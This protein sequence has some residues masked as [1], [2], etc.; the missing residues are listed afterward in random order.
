MILL[1]IAITSVT[2]TALIGAILY[3]IYRYKDSVNTHR[4]D[5]VDYNALN[6]SYGGVNGSGAVL[7]DN[8]IISDLKC[9]NS[10]LSY[11]WQSGGCE[12]LGASS[13]TDASAIA[14]LFVK[15]N[16][17]W[18]GGKFEWISTSRTTRDFTNILKGYN[19][20]PIHAAAT[21]KEFAFVILRNNKR[22]NTLYF[23]R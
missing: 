8:S 14:C 7:V 4:V 16:G 22:T 13:A 17:T 1:Y 20:W 5:Q 18:V 15:K 23:K 10:G 3:F 19:K 11:R 6:W 12:A 2:V 9:S 21:A